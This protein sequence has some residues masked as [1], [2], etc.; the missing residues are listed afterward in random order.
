[1][2]SLR[3]LADT[4]PNRLLYIERFEASKIT[5]K[6]FFMTVKDYICDKKEWRRCDE[7]FIAKEYFFVF[8]FFNAFT[9]MIDEKAVNDNWAIDVIS[10]LGNKIDVSEVESTINNVLNKHKYYTAGEYVENDI[11]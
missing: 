2:L 4:E 10:E 1:M 6:T 11:Y 8:S 5:P 9:E 7:L 3:K